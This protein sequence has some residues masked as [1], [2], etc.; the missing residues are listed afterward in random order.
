MRP[1]SA[2]RATLAAV[3]MALTGIPGLP[4]AAARDAE[5]P[6]AEAH[7]HHGALAIPKAVQTE[8]EAIHAA[9]VEA[10]RA[11]GRVGTAANELAK[12]LHPHFV[13]EE[14]IAL[15]PLGLLAP[16]ARGESHAEMA[17]VLALTD[18]L[19]AELPHMIEEHRA[20]AAAT[21]RLGSAAQLEGQAATA[22]LAEALL[23]HA[24]MEEQVMYPAAIVVGDLV[25]ARGLRQA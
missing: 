7:A 18:S 24:A 21:R 16:L 15:P 6:A 14:Q 9:L 19:R 8:H 12:V 11:P 22:E 25:R 2:V 23:A 13:R 3:L 4:R 5:P 1:M 17:D 10:T 20:I